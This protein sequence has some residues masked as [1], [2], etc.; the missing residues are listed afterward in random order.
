[1]RT[2]KLSNLLLRQFIGHFYKSCFC[3]VTQTKARLS[4]LRSDWKILRA[5][6]HGSLILKTL[7]QGCF[8]KMFVT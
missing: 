2:E 5:N 3:G 8:S 6:L 7:F 4:R 1:M